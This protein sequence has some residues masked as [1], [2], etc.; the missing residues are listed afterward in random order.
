MYVHILYMHTL[1]ILYASKPKSYDISC[2]LR[3]FRVE[4]LGLFRLCLG[5]GPE[6]PAE[7]SPKHSKINPKS[8]RF[9]VL[10]FGFWGLGV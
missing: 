2:M 8:N 1:R 6:S 10:G 4:S 5:P 7:I 9:R 3:G